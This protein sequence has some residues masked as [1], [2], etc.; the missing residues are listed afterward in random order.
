MLAAP[1]QKADLAAIQKFPSVLFNGDR[2]DFIEFAQKTHGRIAASSGAPAGG[3]KRLRPLLLEAAIHQTYRDLCIAKSEIL[4]FNRQAILAREIMATRPK[5]L[6]AI[7]EE[8]FGSINWAKTRL[9]HDYSE[10]E[11]KYG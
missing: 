10:Q 6:L 5:D 4:N 8:F 11:L 3:L 7:S 1:N 2:D 9:L